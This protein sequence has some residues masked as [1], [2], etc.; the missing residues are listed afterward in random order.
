MAVREHL[1]ELDLEKLE[2]ALDLVCH[3]F[4]MGTLHHDKKTIIE[5][6]SSNYAQ[7]SA[8]ESIGSTFSRCSDDQLPQNMDAE[9]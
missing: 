1:A 7:T 9:K 8:P 2:E 4:D 5:K 3:F 6:K